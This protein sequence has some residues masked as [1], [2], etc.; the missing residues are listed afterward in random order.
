MTDILVEQI[1]KLPTPEDTTAANR[2]WLSPLKL[3]PDSVSH[4]AFTAL[5]DQCMEGSQGQRKEPNI[6]ILRRH[7][8]LV[9]LNLSQAVFKRRWLMVALNS[10]DSKQLPAYADNNWS[11]RPLAHMIDHL[12]Q[13][14]LIHLRKGKIYSNDP[15]VTRIF[16]TDALAPQLYQFFLILNNPY[17]RPTRS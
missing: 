10:S 2:T 5:V 1:K 9:L 11:A 15:L 8:E 3:N 13:Q 7:W 14:E 4:P 6:S 16:P 17:S 12:D